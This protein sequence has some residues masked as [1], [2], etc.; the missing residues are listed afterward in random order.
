LSGS[1][2]AIIAISTISGSAAVIILLFYFLGEMKKPIE[3]NKTKAYSDYER[4]KRRFA[5][6]QKLQEELEAHKRQREQE[7]KIRK[8]QAKMEENNI[9]DSL[10]QSLESRARSGDVNAFEQWKSLRNT[11]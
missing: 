10:L 3:I 6:E 5:E 2:I 7:E 1:E 11:K 8:H 4:A 9:K